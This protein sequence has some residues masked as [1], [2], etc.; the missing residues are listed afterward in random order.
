MVGAV[1]DELIAGPESDVEHIHQPTWRA[2][3]HSR[4]KANNSGS[5]DFDRN[6]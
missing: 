3:G 4:K 2:G 5:D 6:R 1:G